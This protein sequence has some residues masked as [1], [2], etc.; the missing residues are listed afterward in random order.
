MSA[1][2]RPGTWTEGTMRHHTSSAAR[3][4]KRINAR[5]QAKGFSLLE[6]TLV[7][8][9]IGI[10]IAAAAYTLVGASSR[11]K[12]QVT[13]SS[14]STIKGALSSY[15]IQHSSYPPTLQTLITTKFLD[16]KPLKDAWGREWMYDPRGRSRDQPYMLG[17]GGEDGQPV[18]PHERPLARTLHT[19]QACRDLLLGTVGPGGTR[20]WLRVIWKPV[21]GTRSG[22]QALQPSQ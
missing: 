5:R 8:A 12:T 18:P 10:L 14:M 3:R 15:N 2:K 20:R 1:V 4:T 11:A 22:T 13:K 17:S 6:L 21:T 9:I 16:D 7:L 19:G